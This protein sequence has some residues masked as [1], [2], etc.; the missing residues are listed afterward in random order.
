MRKEL[1][2]WFGILSLAFTIPVSQYVSSRL[3]LVNVALVVFLRISKGVGSNFFKNS[4]DILIYFTV[5][6]I[7]LSYSENLEAGLRVLETN[8]G[9]IAVPFIFSGVSE[10]DEKK[11]KQLFYSFAFGLSVAC[12]LCLG[13]AFLAYGNTGNIDSFFF[14][15]LTDVL[16][17]Q[18]TY[19]AYYLIFAITVG[20]YF[21]Y[22]QKNARSIIIKASIILFMFLMLMLTGGQTAFV[23]IL[24]IFAFFILKFLIEDKSQV[25]RATI[26]LVV[27][28]LVGMFLATMVAKEDREVILSDSWDRL[29]LW[30][31]AIDAVPSPLIGVGTGDYKS[32]LNQYYVDHSMVEFASESYNSHNQFIQS[33][34]SNGLLGIIAIL[35]MIA[36]PLYVS[37]KNENILAILCLFP[38]LI[39]GITEVFL[40]RYQGIVF[41]AFVHQ[42]FLVQLNLTRP[43]LL[44]RRTE[45]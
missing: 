4:W 43:T 12:L 30:E 8:L 6:V 33:L 9:L 44:I 5:L 22:Y 24:L 7:G 1:V 20:L 31:S 29:V 39:Y 28:M 2:Y 3:L 26:T 13:N 25:K 21:L 37:F 27:F 14:Y 10:L 34:F 15:N 42:S 11:L 18:P 36:R 35:L 41:F 38:F 32:V 16:N 17:F 19:F 40:G 23:S 45:F